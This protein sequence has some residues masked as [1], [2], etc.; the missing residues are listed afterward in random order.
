MLQVCAVH[1]VRN[2]LL[3]LVVENFKEF[4]LFRELLYQLLQNSSRSI[5]L[6][7]EVYAFSA[8]CKRIRGYMNMP[9]PLPHDGDCI[10]GRCGMVHPGHSWIPVESR[11]VLDS[12]IQDL[13]YSG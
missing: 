3:A 7:L 9:G 6:V 13:D 5:K 12:I 11:M 2:S 1:L 4:G 8:R 10:Q